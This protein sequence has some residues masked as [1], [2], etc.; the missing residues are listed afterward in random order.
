MRTS[1]FFA[2]LL[3]AC[4]SPP[5]PASPVA[6]PP[7][8]SPSP[9]IASLPSMESPESQ[10]SPQPTAQ[11]PVP[12]QGELEHA[13][14]NCP[15]AVAG[16]TTQATNTAFGVDLTITA[17]DPASQRR[18]IELAAKHEGMGDPEGPATRHTGL[19]GGPGSSGRCAVVHTGTTVTFTRLRKGA[20]IHVRAL[21]PD[22]LARVQAI[23]ASRLA[24]IAER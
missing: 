23:V 19:H 22:D 13:M 14:R 24:L 12:L 7:A 10:R 21:L 9:V 6:P 15:T 11:L 5:P 18:I 4:A 2:A 17:N 1:I 3:A 20:V 16:A 8:P